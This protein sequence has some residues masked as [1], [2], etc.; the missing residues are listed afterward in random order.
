[1]PDDL[2][3]IPRFRGKR[4]QPKD[5]HADDYRAVAK[6]CERQV[7]EK[8]AHIFDPDRKVLGGSNVF[9]HIDQ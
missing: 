8:A 4:N 1:M 5:F 9:L 2:P 7:L 3:K 6:F